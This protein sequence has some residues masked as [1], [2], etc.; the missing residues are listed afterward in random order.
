MRLAQAPVNRGDWAGRLAPNATL[1]GAP[2]NPYGLKE[3]LTNVAQVR[4]E[5]AF[6]PDAGVLNWP[7]RRKRGQSRRR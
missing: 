1:N 3:R 2:L 5:P 7:D 6:G 4:R